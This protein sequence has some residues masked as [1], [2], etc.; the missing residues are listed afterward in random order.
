MRYVGTIPLWFIRISAVLLI[1]TG[2]SGCAGFM[3]KFNTSIFDGGLSITATVQNPVTMEQ[4]AAVELSYTIAAKALLAYARQPR[5]PAGTTVAITCS[6]WPVVLKLQNANRVAFAQL[7]NLRQFMDTNNQVSAI[8]AFNAAVS[9]LRKF[10][11]TA[12]VEGIT[13]AA[14]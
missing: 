2:A 13:I 12:Y 14:Q 8:T 7:Q 6:S 9:A 10:R 1:V 4:Q 5:C 3:D 11:A